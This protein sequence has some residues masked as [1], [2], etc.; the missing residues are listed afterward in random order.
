MRLSISVRI[1]EGFLSKEEAT[2]TLDDVCSL[3]KAAGFEAVCMRA[4]QVGV[5]SS[6]ATIAEACETLKRHALPVS[7]V[8]GD[9]DTVYNNEKGPASLRH[10]TP[11]LDLAEALE[12]TLIRVALKETDD[13]PHAQRA[14]DEAA[15]RGLHLVHQCHT[16]SLFESLE[17]I[18]T[19][20]KAIARPNFGLIYEPANLEGCRQDYG[21]DALKRLAPWI[22][23]VYL[24]NQQLNP[25]GD[26]TL[27]TWVAGPVSFDLI[28]IYQSGGIDFAR[29]FEGLQAIHYDGT[30]TVHQSAPLE[31]SALEDA[32]RT[33]AFLRGLM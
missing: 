26:I 1:A 21:P 5:H 23:N 31:G 13:I 12:T 27:D 14:A 30:I 6:E 8:T 9:F 4:S 22:A 15:E 20:L 11:Y 2:M 18:E 33:A 10:I 16:L 29:V 28:P 19:T 24:Q 25:N 17:S 32:K 3:A 7:M